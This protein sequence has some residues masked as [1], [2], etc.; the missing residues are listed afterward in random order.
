MKKILLILL[1][2]CCI[3]CSE[4]KAIKIIRIGGFS[5]VDVNEPTRTSGSINGTSIISMNGERVIRKDVFIVYLENG[6]ILRIPVNE[7]S[8]FY[9]QESF[10]FS[11][12]VMKKPF[13]LTWD[14]DNCDPACSDKYIVFIKGNI[15]DYIK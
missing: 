9:F 2:F 5:S 7:Q 14:K 6:R 1:L 13:G 12:V 15:D 10:E 4:E 11:Y 8:Q 3:S